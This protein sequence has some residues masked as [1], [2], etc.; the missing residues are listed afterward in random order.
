MPIFM[1]TSLC[2]ASQ[3]SISNYN[4]VAD[5][6]ILEKSVYRCEF[7]TFNVCIFQTFQNF[8]LAFYARFRALLDTNSFSPDHLRSSPSATCLNTFIL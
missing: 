2:N 4:L 7:L 3:H 6:F 1:F 5:K 8:M